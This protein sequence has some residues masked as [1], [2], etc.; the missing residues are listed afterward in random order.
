MDELRGKTA[1]VTGGAEGIGFSIAR[2]LG[3]Q[4]MNIVLADINADSLEKAADELQKSGVNVLALGLDVADEMRWAA[5][6]EEAV[7]YFG[8]V[9]MLVN[10]A[11]VGGERR[12]LEEQSIETWRWTLDV[13]L[14][15]IVYGAKAT[16]AH[17]K[18]HGEGG[19]I[20][21]VASMAGLGGLPFGGAYNATKSAVVALSEGWSQELA[22]QGIR[23]CVL[24]PAFV[25]TR[26]YESERNRPERYAAS[27]APADGSHPLDKTVE[28]W[29]KSGMDVD[30]VGRR[31][32]EALEA[33]DLYIFTDT[34]I[35]RSA[36]EQRFKMIDAGF[37]SAARSQVLPSA[38]QQK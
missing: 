24:C 15:G 8:K 27:D 4:K 23:V 5:V 21:N 14:M 29:V 26:I 35:Y 7:S 11:G 36:V 22:D 31:L 30:L 19:W 6:F 38:P 33:G 12:P 20:V 13:N 2:A 17:I 32:V 10:N 16:V 37:D 34:G 9:H 25:K 3:E 1:L 18:S 28:D